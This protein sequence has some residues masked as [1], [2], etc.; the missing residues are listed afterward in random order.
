MESK[1]T[2]FAEQVKE[3]AY[4]ELISK[5]QILHRQFMTSAPNSRENFMTEAKFILDKFKGSMSLSDLN[6]IRSNFPGFARLF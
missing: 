2:P 6:Y 5:L 4:N 3:L 1:S